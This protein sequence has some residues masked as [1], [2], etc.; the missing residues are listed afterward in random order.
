V[1]FPSQLQDIVKDFRRILPPLVALALAGCRPPDGERAAPASPPPAD[2]AQEALLQQAAP[3]PAAPGGGVTASPSAS[4]PLPPVPTP[5]AEPEEPDWKARFLSRAEA[6]Q[7]G[8]TAPEPG[9]KVT[10]TMTSGS[11][12]E[13]VIR[14]LD[15]QS[16][17]LIRNNAEMKIPA[18]S[19]A[20]ESR[21]LLFR[22]D[23]GKWRAHQEVLAEYKAWQAARAAREAQSHPPPPPKVAGKIRF[24]V[25][26]VNEADGR[27]PAVVAYL[28]ENLRNPES[29]RILRWG[30]IGPDPQHGWRVTCQ[31]ETLAGD[32]GKVTEHK[33][34]FINDTGEVFQTAAFK[35]QPSPN[36]SSP[37]R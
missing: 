34:F 22:G 28:K 6:L 17:T 35:E 30:K 36:P 27:V 7:S 31:Y 32:F 25:P 10:L 21:A 3:A 14:A 15:E 23:H 37:R 4:R 12:L 2:P 24:P 29:L 9:A 26:P 5:P 20:G 16:V 13:G 33:Y 19:L 8:F 11:V 1:A 18:T